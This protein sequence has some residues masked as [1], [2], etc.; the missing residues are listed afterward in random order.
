MNYTQLQEILRHVYFKGWEFRWGELRPIEGDKNFNRL[1]EHAAF[2]QVRF[3]APDSHTHELEQSWSGRK[4]YV[5][6]H[7]T[8][9]EV[10]QTCLKAVLTAVEHEAREAFLYK[11]I[12]LFQPHLNLDLLMDI[13]TERVLRPDSY[14]TGHYL[15]YPTTPGT[16]LPPDYGEQ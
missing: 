6:L 7:S 13:A 5:S 16:F 4:W 10:V 11:G 2:I 8:E 1:G 12:A 9:A 3:R 14:K 15:D